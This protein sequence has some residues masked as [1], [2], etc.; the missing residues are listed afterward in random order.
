M[1]PWRPHPRSAD[2]C[3]ELLGPLQGR[4]FLLRF[5]LNQRSLLPH[6]PDALVPSIGCLDTGTQVANP[7]AHQEPGSPPVPDVDRPGDLH[8]PNPVQCAADAASTLAAIRSAAEDAR[9]D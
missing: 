9:F 8:I 7:R 2:G 1:W 3:R 4:A 5:N 6:K